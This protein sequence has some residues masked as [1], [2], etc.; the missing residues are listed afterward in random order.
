[1]VR[2]L[3]VREMLSG[4]AGEYCVPVYQRNYAW[5]EA[6]ITQLIQDI[7]DYSKKSNQTYYIGT[8]VVA[9]PQEYGGKYHVV[10]DGQQR[11]TTLSLLVTFLK[12]RKETHGEFAWYGKVNVDFESRE[13]SRR[14]FEVIFKGSDPH[15]LGREGVNTALLEGYQ[16]IGQVFPKCIHDSAGV[17]EQ[18]FTTY[19]LDHVQIM[20]VAVPKKTNLNHYFEIMNSRGEQLE[21]HEII[22]SMLMSRLDKADR[23]CFASIWEACANME[24][25]VQLGFSPKKNKDEPGP[26]YDIFGDSWDGLTLSNF[27]EIR[28]SL[29]HNPGQQGTENGTPLASILEANFRPPEDPEKGKGREGVSDRFSPVIDFPNFLLHVLR[30][31]KDKSIVL[32]DKSLVEKFDEN[33]LKKENCVDDIKRFAFAL[34]K[35]RLLLDR[36]VIKLDY[37]SNSEGWSLKRFLRVESGSFDYKNTFGEDRDELDTNLRLQM[38][39]SAFH[40]SAP[41]KSYKYWLAAALRYLYRQDKVQGDSYLAYL[42]SVARSFVFDRFLK[43]DDGLEYDD[44]IH[45]NE[46]I[47]QSIAE[48]IPDKLLSYGQIKN[49]LVFN[50]LDYLLWKREM[51]KSSGREDKIEKFRFTFRSSVE[52]FYPQT[53][54][55]GME[56][57]ESEDLLHSFG[58]LCLISH[59][60]N[61]QLGNEPPVVKAGY[62]KDGPLDSIKIHLM[63]RKMESNPKV[64]W[65]KDAIIAHHG[66]M[67]QILLNALKDE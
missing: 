39:Q 3:T 24:R 58:N 21:K 60:K 66:E 46:G 15:D 54:K 61:S 63:I 50:Y 59:N 62:Y 6:E 16:I 26:R 22:K 45:T 41:A 19:L 33:I 9:R 49:N 52:H 10:I 5:G 23:T 8:L 38:L 40:V 43:N 32:D 57:L 2:Q 4:K 31:Y 14:T 13:K 65:G 48:H 25:Y 36:Y 27:D 18:Q 1:M 20:Q 35:C 44:I 67:K 53:R 56:P 34:L 64:G 37:L 7:I 11:L 51:S 17:T 42:E 30:V 29:L 55:P 47:C 12:N 28:D